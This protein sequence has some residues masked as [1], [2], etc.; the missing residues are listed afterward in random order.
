[1]TPSPELGHIRN[2]CLLSTLSDLR[3]RLPSSCKLAVVTRVAL[4]IFTFSS[5]PVQISA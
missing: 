4:P 2:G 3:R 5:S 1:M